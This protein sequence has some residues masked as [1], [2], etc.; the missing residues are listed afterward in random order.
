MSQSAQK[1]LVIRNKRESPALAWMMDGIALLCLGRLVI[2]LLSLGLDGSRLRWILVPV[3]L[4]LACRTDRGRQLWKSITCSRGVFIGLCGYAMWLIC[5]LGIGR[6]NDA[7]RDIIWLIFQALPV[8]IMGC[9]YGCQ[10][11]IRFWRILQILLAVLGVQAACSLPYLIAGTWNPKAVMHGATIYGGTAGSF[12]MLDA[13]LHGVGGYDLYMN[14]SVLV[15]IIAGFALY[16]RRNFLYRSFWLLVW[17]FFVMA[18]IVSTFTASALVAISGSVMVLGWVI[19]MRR[20]ALSTAVILFLITG[21]VG[22]LMFDRIQSSG[23][24]EYTVK[25]T[26]N[27]F[28]SVAERGLRADPSKRGDLLFVSLSD[29]L[30]SPIVGHGAQGYLRTQASKASGGGHSTWLNTL[31]QYGLAG[32]VWFFLMVF[33]VGWQIW[34]AVKMRPGDLLAVVFMIAY[35]NYLLFGIINNVMMDVVFFF[36]LYGGA[37]ALQRQAR[38]VQRRVQSPP[39]RRNPTLGIPLSHPAQNNAASRS[40]R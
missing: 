16:I 19:V 37:L 13:A 8:Y 14:T 36:V 7:Q 1:V 35:I 2:P 32:G 6:S 12:F 28:E 33:S 20:L 31:V 3:W 40:F 34:R 5:E 21:L 11:T 18:N 9:F 24:Y 4:M 39:M 27:I 15:N 10:Q 22:G 38:V 29:W 30:E 17:A 25:K 26:S 23:G